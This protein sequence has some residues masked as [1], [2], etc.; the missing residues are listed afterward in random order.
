MLQK[1]LVLHQDFCL[2][3]PP[4]LARDRRSL[5]FLYAA[6]VEREIEYVSLSRDTS[7]SDLKQRKEVVE[8]SRSV[9]VH[10]AP[11][12]AALEGRLLVLDGL[13]KAERNVLPT[14]NNLL[15]NRELSLDDGS[16][17]V[18]AEVFDR[19]DASDL[20]NILRVHP[21]LLH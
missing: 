6:L 21:D 19:H 12:R 16:M 18:S 2:L 3:G 17:L 11:V 20:N 7:D 4:A 9:Y 15:E 5:L 13:E 8:G 14:L 1:D 10:Q